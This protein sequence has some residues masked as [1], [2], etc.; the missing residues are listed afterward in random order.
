MD[1]SAPG[2]HMTPSSLTV[3]VTSCEE[4]ASARGIPLEHELKTLILRTDRGLVAAHIPGDGMLALR[5]VKRALAVTQACLARA[6][7]LQSLGLSRGTVS[8]LLDPVWSMPHL[9]TRRLLTLSLVATNDGTDTGYY[10]FEP[11]VL[12]RAPNVT[13]GDFERDTRHVS[14]VDERAIGALGEV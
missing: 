4:A 9:V 8:A 7:E 13:V 12:L 5:K 2:R 11:A 3:P 10:S 6:D 14:T 1:Q